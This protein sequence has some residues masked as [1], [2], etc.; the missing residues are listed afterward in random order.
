VKD[1]KLL[2][3]F[4][5]AIVLMPLS[6]QCYRPVQETGPLEVGQ[7][8]PA[9]ALQDLEGNDVSLEQYKGEIVIL[10]FWAT[11]CG[12]CRMTMPMLDELQDQYSGKLALLAVNLNEP[13]DVVREY[14][15]N[16]GLGS[17][18]LLDEDGSVG[19]LYGVI[20]IP[21]QVLIDQNGTVQ[22]IMTGVGPGMD[23]KIRAEINKLL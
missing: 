18:V 22:F 12:P 9:F 15:M 10:D 7:A 19:A 6:M 17:R 11:W 14:V 16:E 21:M 8:A 20:G 4:F 2:I 1:K 5:I 13:K 3:V 23:S